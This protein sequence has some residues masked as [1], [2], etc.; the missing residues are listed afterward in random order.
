M[1]DF[2]QGSLEKKLPLDQALAW[3]YEQLRYRKGD[4]SRGGL[5]MPTAKLLKVEDM[6]GS[7][8]L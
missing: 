3:S 1:R 8:E 4:A 2:I 7:D 6:A 5:G